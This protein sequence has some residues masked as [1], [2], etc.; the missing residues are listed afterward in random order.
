M[1]TV[2]PATAIVH[3]MAAPEGKSNHTDSSNPIA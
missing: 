1:N 2:A 3:T